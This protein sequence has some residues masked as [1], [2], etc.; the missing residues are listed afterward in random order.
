M[1]QIE[2]KSDNQYTVNQSSLEGSGETQPEEDEQKKPLETLE[3]LSIEPTNQVP[4]NQVDDEKKISLKRDTTKSSSRCTKIL[5]IRRCAKAIEIRVLFMMLAGFHIYFV[6]CIYSQKFYYLLFA[7]YSILI[8][9]AAWVVFK[10]DGYDF[11]W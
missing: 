2:E 4:T 11:Y 9:D 3:A 10:R 1:N 5:N 6:A 8:L 7:F